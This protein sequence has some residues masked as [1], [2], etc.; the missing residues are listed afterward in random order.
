MAPSSPRKPSFEVN[1]G[2]YA[3]N[4]NDPNRPNIDPRTPPTTD[5]ERQNQLSPRVRA[6]HTKTPLGTPLSER[7]TVAGTSPT[8]I[9]LPKVACTAQRDLHLQEAGKSQDR[10]SET[11]S[12]I[13]P[14]RRG[15]LRIANQTEGIEREA[16]GTRDTGASEIQEQSQ[17]AF[18]AR[19]VE[20]QARIHNFPRGEKQTRSQRSELSLYTPVRVPH[21]SALEATKETL[22]QPF[23]RGSSLKE[24]QEW[25][26]WA[27]FVCISERK[28]LIDAMT[29]PNYEYSLVC[30]S[31]DREPKRARHYKLE[32]PIITSAR[33]PPSQLDLHLKVKDINENGYSGDQLC[34]ISLESILN[35]VSRERIEQA[36]HGI[37]VDKDAEN[38]S[39]DW[40]EKALRAFSGAGLLRIVRL[41][42]DDMDCIWHEIEAEGLKF[43]QEVRFDDHKKYGSSVQVMNSFVFRKEIPTLK[44]M[45]A[46]RMEP[47]PPKNYEGQRSLNS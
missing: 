32:I 43:L 25:K 34:L 37:E 22:F 7:H 6:P 16:A 20:A 12:V 17:Y 47:K 21:S 19:P 45:R 29:D 35:I 8:S 44:L 15:P 24:I 23:R 9:W 30:S 33:Q 31:L 41:W 40:V 26:E 11:Q 1:R 10:K 46:V 27:M 3:E 13:D 42:L 2:G 28:N 39:K 18:Q 38:P 4:N 36:L 5:A 14:D